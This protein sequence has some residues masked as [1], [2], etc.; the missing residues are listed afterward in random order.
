MDLPEPLRIMISRILLVLLCFISIQSL[1]QG[2][3]KP[4]IRGQNP[5]STN[6]DQSVTI[7]MSSLDVEDPDDWF[8]PWGFTMQL[9]AGDNYTFQGHV[10][11]PNR[12]FS[13]TL[14]VKVTVHDGQDLS[15][16]F[17]LKVTVHPM[18]D[19]PVI[20][21]HSALSTNEDKPITIV[22]GNLTVT[23]PDDKYPDD[24][25][26]RV[27]NGNNYS[28]S[29]S[30]VTP[31]QGFSGSLSVNVSVNDGS[32]DSDVYAL[33]VKVN[34]IN[35]VPVI[36]GQVTLQVNEDESIAILLS[37]LNVTDDD[38]NYPQGFTLSIGAGENYTFTS[39]TV[40]PS[41]DF[42]GR[43]SIPITVNDGTNTS[44][45]FNLAVTVT[46]VND[47]PVV[48]SL[49]TE[50]L[51]YGP[52][53][54][55]ISITNTTS[56]REVDG[57]SIMFAEVRLSED[58]YQ[59]NS[60]R[61]QF[62]PTSNNKIRGVFDSNAGILTL[63]GQAS[64]ASYAAALASVSYENLA[65]PSGGT[66]T[67]QISVNDGKTDSEIVERS[68]VFGHASFSLDIPTGFTPNGDLANDT[69]K[70]LPLRGDESFAQAEIKV[71]SKT[72]VL[73]FETTG[74]QNE[75]DGRLNGQFLPAD[76]YFYTIDL[77]KN[78]PEGFLKGLVTILR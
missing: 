41:T 21:G 27:H 17:D 49:E 10:V 76:T 48:T 61:L 36:N 25:T 28:V 23:D 74:F 70:I 62:T 18:N 33:P 65:P 44:K 50:P 38:S 52:S 26:L 66:K 46:P 31:Q 11:T 30:Q 51:F 67:L 14:T 13:G 32:V 40:R 42:F 73:V 59:A 1:G 75:W 71:Y 58:S 78:A 43:L 34:A 8:Y 53:D 35:R 63:L 7:L 68:I 57:D 20:T 72:G 19:K 15:N 54:R 64:P 2:N 12:D 16:T 77:N 56:I 22:P 6:E 4:K 37:H 5:I 3:R 69:W 60:D 29:G 55:R 45:P 39:N 47:I 9:Y 24:F